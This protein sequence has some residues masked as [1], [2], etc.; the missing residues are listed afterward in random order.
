M[1]LTNTNTPVQYFIRLAN[2]QEIGPYPSREQAS[3]S[4]S[5]MP[6]SEGA[7]ILPRTTAGQQ[8]LFG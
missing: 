7:Q 2:G 1:L 3:L 6:M 5:T 4:V 8:V